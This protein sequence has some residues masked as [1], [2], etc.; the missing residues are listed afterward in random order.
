[1]SLISVIVPVYNAQEY[2]QACI[3]S[4]LDQTFR[5]FELI[6]VNDGSTD[7]S[8][9]LCDRYAERDSRIHVIHQVNQGQA[10]A[11]NRALRQAAGDWI[12][13]V[14]SDDL[15]HPQMLELLYH[16]VM[17]SGSGMSMCSYVEASSVPQGFYHAYDNEFQI[18]NLDEPT[19]VDLYRNSRYPSWVVWFKLIRKDSILKHP[20][21]E[22][23][24]YEDNAVVCKW[25]YKAKTAAVIPH[26]MYF[27]RINPAGTTKSEF[28]LKKLDYLWALREII[29]FF[30][31]VNYAQLREI[32]CRNYVLASAD[33]Y[34]KVIDKLGRRDIAKR[35]KRD[36]ICVWI[37]NRKYIVL[38]RQQLMDVIG[39]FHPKV[40]SLRDVFSGQF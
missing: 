15:I 13:F 20:F 17:E 30:H 6:L 36:L 21:T 4:I 33:F 11:R 14:D 1:M 8:P 32:F 34:W 5:D 24:V 35:I 40:N 9:E 29:S 3:D 27:Y 22:G 25:V 19:L 10:A 39:C 26:R 2:L 23:R 38:S 37:R 28:S 16:A 12:C 31:E 7:N 18:V